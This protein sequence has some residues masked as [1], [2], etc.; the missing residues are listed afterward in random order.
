MS[1]TARVLPIEEWFRL[2]EECPTSPLAAIDLTTVYG[3]L[4]V[5]END[6]ECTICFGDGWVLGAP[7]GDQGMTCSTCEGTGK[8]KR[9]VGHWPL[10]LVWHAE[11][12]YIAPEH[13]NAASVKTLVH[14]LQS[15]IA[16]FSVPVAFAMIEDPVMQRQAVKLGFT[17]TAAPMYHA[18]APDEALPAL[19]L[20]G[21]AGL[22]PPPQEK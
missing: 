20:A 16:E 21:L 8:R 18:V 6:V 15:A 17:P 2:R 22:A 4:V 13:R 7:N 19:D 9:I 10:V 14:G 3:H 12:L 5:L 11:P 1:Y